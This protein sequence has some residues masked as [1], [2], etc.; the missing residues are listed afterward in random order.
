M[1]RSKKTFSIKIAS[2]QNIN[3]MRPKLLH[4]AFLISMM[5]TN[6]SAQIA[7]T[8]QKTMGGSAG[9]FFISLAAT[10]DGGVI[11]GGTSYSDMSFEKSE[12]GRGNGDYW[13]VKT[14]KD[15]KIQWDKTIGGSERDFGD[16]WIVT[17]SNDKQSSRTDSSNQNIYR[18][19]VQER[20][21]D[22]PFTV[23]P[24]PVRNILNIYTS[25]KAFVSLTDQSGKIILIRTI[26]GNGLIDFSRLPAGVRILKNN[27]TGETKKIM[28][29]K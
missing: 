10:R 5:Y 15:G 21:N 29:G 8:S 18:R 2:Y 26:D 3:K 22:V 4:L 19:P 24:D 28:V 23:Y 25:S 17:L 1:A 9:D 27:T 16:Y 11:S 20:I 12:N 7:I 14:D 6:A 13:V